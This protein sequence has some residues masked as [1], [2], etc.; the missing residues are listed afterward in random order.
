V[1]PDQDFSVEEL[2]EALGAQLDRTQDAMRLKAVNR[3]LTYAIRDFSLELKAFVAMDDRGE[4]RL[5]STGPDDTGASTL[6]IGFTTM[7]APMVEEAAIPLSM[8][9]GPG[10]D[11]LGLDEGER[12]RLARLGVHNAAQLRRL[13]Q[14]TDQST[15]SRWADIPVNRLRAALQLGRP[16]VS[17]VE[18]QTDPPPATVEPGPVTVEPAPVT[19]EPGPATVEPAPGNGGTPVEPP[20][21]GPRNVRLTPGAKRLRL[22]GR[23][24]L[25][26]TQ[27][28]VRLGDRELPVLEVADE[29]VVVGLPEGTRGGR[30][31]VDI[32]GEAQVFALGPDDGDPWTPE[33]D[34]P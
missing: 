9:R 34:S 25:G 3:P 31:S 7:T 4:V 19:V 16:T 17:H 13:G 5:R 8:A 26:D 28:V 32:G 12:R 27:P 1:P 29:H 23:N 18:V 20:V 15:V 10:L 30:L 24:L 2:L 21:R 14:V 33:G 22:A 6:H 11:A